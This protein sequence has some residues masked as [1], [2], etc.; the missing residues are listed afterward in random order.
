MIKKMVF[1]MVFLFCLTSSAFAENI[2]QP[3]GKFTWEDGLVDVLLKTNDIKGIEKVT[4]EIGMDQVDITGI[5]T[6]AEL[7]QKLIKESE[8]K[9]DSGF[10][11]LPTLKGENLRLEACKGIDKKVLYINISLTANPVIIAGIPFQMT[12]AFA[13]ADGLLV[14]SQEKALK[15][16]GENSGDYYLPLVIT[17]VFLES[18]STTLP[19]NFPK[20]KE[21][22]KN[23]YG[24]FSN[25]SGYDDKD[26]FKLEVRDKDQRQ[27]RMIGSFFSSKRIC[28]IFYQ[29][30]AYVNQLKEIYRNYLN[31]M[32]TEKLKGKEDMSSKM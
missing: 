23:K 30:N 3:F 8:A 20:L 15:L 26:S 13:N 22:V 5:R 6:E 14:K 31:R 4:L 2:V 9:D 21:I 16:T 27:F 12:V 25:A 19:E 24:G 18:T 10:D 28:N 29:S 7:V 17:G 11:K 32:E 1:L